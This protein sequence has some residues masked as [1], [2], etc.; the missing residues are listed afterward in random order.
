MAIRDALPAIT[1]GTLL[2]ILFVVG[3]W[4]RSLMAPLVT[5]ASAG[6]AYLVAVG[7]V[8]WFGRST[9]RVLPQEVEPLI[10]V[11]VLGIVT[12]YCVFLLAE[13]RRRLGTGARRRDAARGA[14]AT[15][16]PTILTAGL[17]VAGGT[18][19]LAFGTLG[20]F[21]A[22]GPALAI[23]A[24][25][26][27]LV[28][29]TLVP[30]LLAIVAP[31]P[32]AADEDTGVGTGRAR[33]RAP[34]AGWRAAG[35]WPCR[36]RCC[37]SPASSTPPATSVRHGSGSRSRR[38]SRTAP[39]RAAPRT[40]R[41]SAS[42]AGIISPTELQLTGSGIA[43]QTAAL[44]RVEAGLRRIAGVSAVVGPAEQARAASAPGAAQAF[45]SAAGP[46]AQAPFTAPNGNAARMLVVTRADPFSSGAITTVEHVQS[47]LPGLLRE[48]GLPGT[49][50]ALAG[51]TALAAE[52]IDQ[53]KRDIV[54]LAL[55][56]LAVNLLMLVVFLRA[57]VAPVVLLG[58][59]VLALGA[60]LGIAA[61]VS[62]LLGWG[63]I[64]YFTPLAAAV[65]LL[66]LG[67][68][69]NVFVVGRIWD[70]ARRR[71]VADAV[72]TALPAAAKPITLAGLVLAGSFALLALA[73][74]V[75]LRQLAVA[76]AA[77]VLLDAF[78]VRSLLVP[79]LLTSLGPVAGWPGQA[80]RRPEDVRPTPLGA[81]L[82]AG[83]DD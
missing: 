45:R 18:A 23:A 64:A 68:D 13:T 6:T 60:A 51:Q 69:Y 35:W 10:L 58:A 17:I 76:L 5:L 42:R 70:E 44:G 73:P 52:T 22:L 74:V 39:R 34:R 9:G 28:A 78:V 61:L 3:L 72:A 14:A 75:A 27:T 20:F 8:G 83:A 7:V 80:L 32:R 63:D 31:R 19:S 48:A 43:R 29:L 49:Q 12:D 40:P 81:P 77:G 59:S 37:A 66:S 82:G 1:V 55:I 56:A 4:Q 15:T 57:L 47:T 24:G 71:P 54:R 50:T 26:G 65:L 38:V 67:S 33:R 79:S 16:A 30:A 25:V 21:R 36:W 62:R 53:A 41:G 46:A 2:L 11:L